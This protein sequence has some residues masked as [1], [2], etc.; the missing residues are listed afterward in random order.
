MLQGL[1]GSFESELCVRQGLEERKEKKS[2][3]CD[4]DVSRW[5]LLRFSRQ[6]L[7]LS[8]LNSLSC[9]RGERSHIF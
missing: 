5:A 1:P 8:S 7:D 4:G 9:I 3:A 6:K 2:R